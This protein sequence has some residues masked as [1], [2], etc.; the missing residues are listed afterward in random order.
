M[1]N[2][3]DTVKFWLDLSYRGQNRQKLT[4][5]DD[6]FL[7][8]SAC[9]QCVAFSASLCFPTVYICRQTANQKMDITPT[10]P[11][12][13]ST[14]SPAL[15]CPIVYVP[16]SAITESKETGYVIGCKQSALKCYLMFSL[17]FSK[18]LPELLL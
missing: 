6:S 13:L 18:V 9:G 5:W 4:R 2:A 1:K 10:L 15:P 3:P 7:G 8:I 11:P 16:M 17:N 12:S 14:V